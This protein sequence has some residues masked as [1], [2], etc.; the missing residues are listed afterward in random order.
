VDS[1]SVE[2][3]VFES[4]VEAQRQMAGSPVFESIVEAQRQMAG[5][6]VFES[7]VEAQRQMAGSPVFDRIVDVVGDNRF[8]SVV[9]EL[10]RDRDFS[11]ALAD[12]VGDVDPEGLIDEVIPGPD[13]EA[14]VRTYLDSSSSVSLTASQLEHLVYFVIVT[15]VTASVAILVV[16]TSAQFDGVAPTIGFLGSIASLIALPLAVHATLSARSPR[17]ADVDAPPDSGEVDRNMGNA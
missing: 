2:S 14:M 1:Y 11:H 12:I 3:A 7:I 6:P 4:I 9:E 10:L 15:W 16:I 13:I 5:S 8:Q 17:S